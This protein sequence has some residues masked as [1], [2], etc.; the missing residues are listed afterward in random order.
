ML[1]EIRCIHGRNAYLHIDNAISARIAYVSTVASQFKLLI[2]A[3][4]R[5]LCAG[6]NDARAQ[7]RYFAPKDNGLVERC[8]DASNSWGRPNNGSCRRLA[9]IWSLVSTF[10]W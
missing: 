10:L 5:M 3:A 8:E 2:R 9:L 6:Q 4:G 7:K 1:S